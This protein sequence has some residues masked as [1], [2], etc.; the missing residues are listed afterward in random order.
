MC[1]FP[2][3]RGLDGDPRSYGQLHHQWWVSAVGRWGADGDTRQ[4]LESGVPPSGDLEASQWSWVERR[5]GCG[6]GY[7]WPWLRRFIR[8]WG[9]FFPSA[10]RLGGEIGSCLE[11]CFF[12]LPKIKGL[13]Q[14]F[15]ELLE[16]L[17]GVDISCYIKQDN[18]YYAYSWDYRANSTSCCPKRTLKL[19]TLRNSQKW[20]NNTFIVITRFTCWF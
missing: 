15:W 7:V 20:F 9:S 10:K 16:M 11:M 14:S 1:P 5:S 19:L 17:L 8:V 13:G 4:R 3:L 18:A 6:Q 2:S 12:N